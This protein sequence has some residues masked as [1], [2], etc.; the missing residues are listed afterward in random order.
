MSG[1]EW[2]ASDFVPGRARDTT[3]L[4][5][6]SALSGLL[7]YV[8]FALSTR[9]LGAAQAAPISV[10]WTYWSFAA[11]ALTF[12]LQH[13]IARTVA[14][15]GGEGAVHRA[16]PRLA[17][18]VALVSMAAGLLAWSTRDALFHRDDV[19]FPVLV[20][21]VTLGSGFIGVVRGGLAARRRFVSVAWALVAEN[22]TRC[23]AAIALI[24][25]QVRASLGYGVCLAA[26]SLIGL[27]WPSAV[28]F[29]R[30]P[31]PTL[32][33]P[34]SAFRFL[35]GTASGQLVGQ[36]VLTGGPVLLAVSGGTAAQVTALFAGLALFRAP[37]TLAIG[38]VSQLTGRLTTLFVQGHRAA[39]RRVRILVLAAT[40]VSALGAG[41][42]GAAVGPDLLRL[43]FGDDV[44]LGWFPCLLLAGGSALALANLV[45][46]ILIMA[47]GRSAAVAR[48]W[49]VGSLGGATVFALV[50]QQPLERTCWTFVAAEAVTFAVMLVEEMRGSH[51]PAAGHHLDLMSGEGVAG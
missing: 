23:A 9:A 24:A 35:G 38:L 42:A 48:A 29:A 28:R 25:A 18:V 33:N 3:A 30:Q 43:I 31:A 10:L 13:W 40:A 36:V 37:Y 1:G 41:A 49:V 19:W 15:H 26:G 20:A 44:R 50:A 11:A 8:F 16:L 39:L 45:M 47:Q 17:A 51:Q 7:A 32:R 5:A 27:L 21:W 2:L 6:G 22:G 14:A 46:T 4:A 34:E 12:P